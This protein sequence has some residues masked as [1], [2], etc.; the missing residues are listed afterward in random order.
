MSQLDAARLD[1]ELLQ[2]I[3]DQ[4]VE[5]FSGFSSGA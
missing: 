2:L 3:R 5:V 4:L 1:T